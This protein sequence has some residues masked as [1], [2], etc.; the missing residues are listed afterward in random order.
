MPMAA[1][2]ADV[3][4]FAEAAYDE[5]DMVV[6]VYANITPNILSYGVKLLYDDSE[7]TVSS[8]E[9]NENV[10]YF[11]DGTSAGNYDY[12]EPET[13]TVG[14]V[15][16]IGGKLDTAGPT[17]GVTG[18]RILLGK[19]FFDRTS[20]TMPFSPALSLDYG[21]SGDYKNFVTTNGAILD[22]TGVFF[23]AIVVAEKGDANADGSINSIDAQYVSQIFF[24]SSDWT[25]LA[26]CN[27]DGN[28]NSIDAQCISQKFF[29]P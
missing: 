8:A 15:I 6:Y 2:S 5:D 18:Q 14:E 19:V 22:G 25:I 13:G 28:I 23:D 1:Y 3:D 17:D 20:S 29:N 16:I 10:W 4:V 11:G 7:L 27:G 9:K 24:G 12:M 21:R 26:D